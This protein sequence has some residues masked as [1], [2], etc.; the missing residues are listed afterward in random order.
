MIRVRTV[1]AAILVFSQ[2]CEAQT[3]PGMPLG[4]SHQSGS[5]Y[6]DWVVS[7]QILR[8]QPL[9]QPESGPPPLPLSEAVSIAKNETQ[10]RFPQIK[11]LER[12]TITLDQVHPQQFR[13]LWYY[14]IEYLVYPEKFPR[15]F[16]SSYTVYL[17][18]DGT[19]IE[20]TVRAEN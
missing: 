6:V 18:M 9:W 8:R 20:P 12:Y 5:P 2:G 3:W 17:M 7:G 15:P 1:L 10:R 4:S 16:G 19:V 13:G 11:N 14:K